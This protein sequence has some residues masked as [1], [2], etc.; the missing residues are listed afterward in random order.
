M[1]SWI[2]KDTSR[3]YATRGRDIEVVT[4]RYIVLNVLPWE[5]T[6]LAEPPLPKVGDPLPRRTPVGGARTLASARSDFLIQVRDIQSNYAPGSNTDAEV[7]ITYASGP[8][9][10]ED[11]A[12]R[13]LVEWSVDNGAESDTVFVDNAGVYVPDGLQTLVPTVTMRARLEG[14]QLQRG[15]E[16]AVGKFNKFTFRLFF[17]RYVMLAGISARG[18]TSHDPT[19]GKNDLEFEFIGK[20]HG[21]A[22]KRPKKTEAGKIVTDTDGLPVICEHHTGEELDFR[23]LFSPLFDPGFITFFD[24]YWPIIP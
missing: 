18:I 12:G 15:W 4:R 1:A 23:T 21:W 2:E 3:P 17:P 10:H 19:V 8:N 5:A 13:R 6:R 20:P 11:N 7:T 16:T 22:Q 24:P 14:G 9:W